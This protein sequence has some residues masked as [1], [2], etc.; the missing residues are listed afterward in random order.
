ML[1]HDLLANGQPDPRSGIILPSVEA[2]KHLEETGLLID[3][4]ADAIIRDGEHPFLPLSFCGDADLYCFL[5]TELDGIGDKVLQ[6]LGHL[7]WIGRDLR[8]WSHGH[9]RLGFL[10]L[11]LKVLPYRTVEN[12]IDGV[13][14]TFSDIEAQKKVQEKLEDLSLEARASQEYAESIVNTLKEPL[15]ILDKGLIVRSANTTFYKRF[16]TT[17]ENV[18]GRPVSE[19]MNGMWDVRPVISR[20]KDLST[21]EAELEN[22]SSEIVI[23]KL[24]KRGVDITARKLLIP[25][26]KSTMILINFNIKE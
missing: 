19:I 20:L 22:L 6:E 25:S 15:L 7:R 26:G 3:G 9:D 10:H 4:D 5:G 14:I 11:T 8:Q 12:V 18:R 2:L 17:P 23:P 13:V 21:K 24:G 16:E 1:L